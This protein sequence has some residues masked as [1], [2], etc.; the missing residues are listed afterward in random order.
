MSS[1]SYKALSRL[2]TCTNFANMWEWDSALYGV[3]KKRGKKIPFLRWR[4]K[5]LSCSHCDCRVQAY[6]VTV[7]T[8]TTGKEKEVRISDLQVCDMC[9]ETKHQNDGGTTIFISWNRYREICCDYLIM[10]QPSRNTLSTYP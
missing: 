5:K 9:W 10:L 8:V 1:P 6:F 2:M 7:T 4:G 3:E